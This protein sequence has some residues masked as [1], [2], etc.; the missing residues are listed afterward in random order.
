MAE[1]DLLIFKDGKRIGF[2][3]KYTD[4]PKITPSIKIS[5]EVLK[6]DQIIKYRL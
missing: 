2:E 5:L 1:I 4:T 3:F 6:L